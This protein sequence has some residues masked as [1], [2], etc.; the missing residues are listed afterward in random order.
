MVRAGSHICQVRYQGPPR[1]NQLV[2]NFMG[3]QHRVALILHQASLVVSNGNS[4]RKTEQKEGQICKC[5]P[6]GVTAMENAFLKCMFLNLPVLNSFFACSAV[7]GLLG[8][9]T[10][11]V[12]S[13][14]VL[15]E[16]FL[17]GIFSNVGLC[18]F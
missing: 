14:A 17:M 4:W 18:V 5:E 9:R 2:F 1:T 15:E 8:L 11:A 10:A 7:P 6:M 16:K 3:Q 13:V 12:C